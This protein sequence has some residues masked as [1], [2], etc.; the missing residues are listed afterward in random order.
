MSNRAD[1]NDQDDVSMIDSKQ[2]MNS[3]I[4]DEIDRMERECEQDQ[5][6]I[7]AR[8]EKI[9]Q[10][11]N[12]KSSQLANATNVYSS[13]HMDII[14][15]IL[16]FHA[17]N[18]CEYVPA[19]E[20]Q[21]LVLKNNHFAEII[22]LIYGFSKADQKRTPILVFPSLVFDRD[23]NIIPIPKGIWCLN[24]RLKKYNDISFH[25]SSTITSL[26]LNHGPVEYND[27]KALTRN[28]KDLRFLRLERYSDEITAEFTELL[29]KSLRSL[30][31]LR[32]RDYTNALSSILKRLVNLTHLEIDTKCALTLNAP[33]Q[34]RSLQI[35]TKGSEEKLE[36]DL[37]QARRLSVREVYLSLSTLSSIYKSQELEFLE[38]V[39]ATA[40]EWRF[41]E[42]K[43]LTTLSVR[44][45][46]VTEIVF[47]PNLRDFRVAYS[48]FASALRTNSSHKLDSLCIFDIDRCDKELIISI[49]R[50]Q[51]DLIHLS[52]E[53]ADIHDRNQLSLSVVKEIRH[54]LPHVKSL[55]LKGFKWESPDIMYELVLL[56][57]I[58]KLDF[59][60]CYH[61]V[62]RDE[63]IAKMGKTL[64]EFTTEEL[65]D[66]PETDYKQETRVEKHE[67]K[68]HRE[69]DRPTRHEEEKERKSSTRAS[70]SPQNNHTTERTDSRREDRTNDQRDDR[71]ND[72]DKKRRR[73]E[74]SPHTR[75]TFARIPCK[76]FMEGHCPYGDTCYYKHPKREEPTRRTSS[77]YKRETPTQ[78]SYFSSS[79][80]SKPAFQESSS[81]IPMGSR[82]FIGNLDMPT[83]TARDIERLFESYGT[84]TEIRVHM[85]YM[86]VQFD[87]PHSAQSSLRGTNGIVMGRKPIAVQMAADKDVSVLGKRPYEDEH[88]QRELSPPNKRHQQQFSPR[89]AKHS[90]SFSS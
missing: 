59:L 66:L 81:R 32:S 26:T 75:E 72:H 42:M 8:H 27:I 14:P 24:L 7:E 82:V 1:D 62:S 78:S 15:H 56:P 51:Q 28:I 84:I 22:R 19:Y 60:D 77:S 33:N 29:P 16:S 4:D 9:R 73:R 34:M 13:L 85:G 83:V 38:L 49:S 48:E 65:E 3:F 30:S 31:I 69:E 39:Y 80:R 2:S 55:H 47:P 37:N 45:D 44:M 57:G 87:N 88:E 79:S 25:N 43:S 35:S 54:S 76:F 86:F 6:R 90:M 5:K 41:D 17:L 21:K 68:T 46:T 20:T 11:E 70:P 23:A 36:L 12:Y 52:L 67:E 61:D 10:L 63:M 50:Y 71:D 74:L 89:L 18:V 40:N 53:S 58:V 64:I